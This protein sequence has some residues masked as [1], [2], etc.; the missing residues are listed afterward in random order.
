M[1]L[2]REVKAKM[3]K[4]KTYFVLSVIPAVFFIMILCF[5][6]F[7][8][9]DSREFN[10]LFYGFLF[11]SLNFFLGVLSIHF[12]FEK[13]DNIFLIFVLGGLV[14]RLFLMLILIVIALKFLFVSLYSFIFTTFIL[15]FYYLIVEILIL[16]EKKNF[17]LKTKQ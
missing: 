3:K 15:Y 1:I 11:S 13:S 10:S 2:R 12:G 6:F 7:G 17:I 4:A 14:I 9:L 8:T 5:Y 16:T